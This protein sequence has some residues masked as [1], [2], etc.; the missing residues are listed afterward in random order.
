MLGRERQFQ[1]VACG[2]SNWLEATGPQGPIP[3]G[4][5]RSAV[6][7]CLFFCGGM[8]DAE[9]P[10][11]AKRRRCE[12]GGKGARSLLAMAD[13]FGRRLACGSRR[14]PQR[15]AG[16][17]LRTTFAIRS[18]AKDLL[19]LPRWWLRG[20]HSRSFGRQK[21][22]CA[23]TAPSIRRSDAPS[24]RAQRAGRIGSSSCRRAF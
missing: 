11:T 6:R 16:W 5:N 9:E 10:E 1:S 2:L 17:R 8:P 3:S 22:R 13:G 7:N 4:K 15:S 14:C 19:S 21:R 18:D 23:V 12:A 20:I 24:C